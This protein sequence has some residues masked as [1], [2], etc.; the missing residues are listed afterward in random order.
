MILDC[1][2]SFLNNS[3]A[4]NSFFKCRIALDADISLS[5][6]PSLSLWTVSFGWLLASRCCKSSAV[7]NSF[8]LTVEVSNHADKSHFPFSLSIM[9]YC[10]SH[11]L[12]CICSFAVKVSSNVLHLLSAMLP[13]DCH[14]KIQTVCG[15]LKLKAY[16][17]CTRIYVLIY[18]LSRLTNSW[19]YLYHF[20]CLRLLTNKVEFSKKPCKPQICGGLCHHGKINQTYNHLWI[21]IWKL[22][23]SL[24]VRLL[25]RCHI[26]TIQ[27]WS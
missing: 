2:N 22:V 8:S 10:C 13:Q 4:L 6:S 7:N 21:R 19:L 3:G 11:Y 26:V 15:I 17:P 25:E 12:S 14:H 23:V 20:L 24:T 1:C 9:K 18:T 16:I 27:F 5:S